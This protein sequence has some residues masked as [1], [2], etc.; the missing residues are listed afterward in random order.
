VQVVRN[1]VIETRLV[2]IGFHSDNDT[3]IRSGLQEGDM[4]VANA[5]SSLRDGDK[6]APIVADAARTGQR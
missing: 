4:V 3:E 6:V 1:D 5:G 2:Q